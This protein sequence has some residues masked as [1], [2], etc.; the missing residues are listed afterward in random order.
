MGSRHTL[1]LRSWQTRLPSH[2][3]PRSHQ[4]PKFVTEFPKVNC[5]TPLGVE[6]D[7]PETRTT[8]YLK[9]ASVMM[10]QFITI[11]PIPTLSLHSSPTPA[12]TLPIVIL[13]ELA[14]RFVAGTLRVE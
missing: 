1:S 7:P 10:D 6:Q 13:I 9:T 12:V 4:R 5:F 8:S 14:L 11:L 3:R 2:R